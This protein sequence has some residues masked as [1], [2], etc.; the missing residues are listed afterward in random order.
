MRSPSSRRTGTWTVSSRYGVVRTAYSSASRSRIV[1]ACPKYWLTASCG[2]S[3]LM[4][5]LLRG[6]VARDAERFGDARDRSGDP[7]EL[8]REDDF[9][10]R[11]VGHDLQ[12]L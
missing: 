7:G 9:R 3:S 5:S 2:C 12:R 1:A 8:D 4:P 10:G 6:P 11:A